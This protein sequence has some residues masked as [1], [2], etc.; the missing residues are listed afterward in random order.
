[1]AYL[2]DEISDEMRDRFFATI[3]RGTARMQLKYGDDKHARKN[4]KKIEIK[5]ENLFT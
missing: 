3:D 1:M 4:E 5:N 2:T